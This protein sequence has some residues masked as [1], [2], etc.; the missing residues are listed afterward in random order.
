M[1]VI[2]ESALK[3]LLRRRNSSGPLRDATR[4]LIRQTIAQ[5]HAED[6]GGV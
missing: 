5:I 3:I 6:R 1:K 2:A 4:Q